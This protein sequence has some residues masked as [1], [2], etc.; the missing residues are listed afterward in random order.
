MFAPNARLRPQVVP[1]PVND[2]PPL[3]LELFVKTPRR[4]DHSKYRLRWAVLFRRTFRENISVCVHCSAPVRIL[5]YATD[6]DELHPLLLRHREPLEAPV[7]APV[8]SPPQLELAGRAS[9][10]ED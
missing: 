3:Q 5:A 10:A 6:P 1:T 7:V 4:L 9:G 2:N 8:R